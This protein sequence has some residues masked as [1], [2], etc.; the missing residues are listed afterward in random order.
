MEGLRLSEEDEDYGNE[1]SDKED[2]E[3]WERVKTRP[4]IEFDS[5]Q[6][7]LMRVA[8]NEIPSVLSLFKVQSKLPTSGY[9]VLTQDILGYFLSPV[10]D[11]IVMYVTRVRSYLASRGESRKD[12]FRTHVMPISPH[13]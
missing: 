9:T 11:M 6:Q 1:V 10:V 7:M 3:N 2:E 4:E 13:P 8:M 12:L 5:T